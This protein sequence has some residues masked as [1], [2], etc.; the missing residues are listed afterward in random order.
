[1]R[2]TISEVGIL[3]YYWILVLE[4]IKDNILVGEAKVELLLV[5]YMYLF[6][7]FVWDSVIVARNRE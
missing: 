6:L 3:E 1:M 2:R 5:Y 7:L 4:Q